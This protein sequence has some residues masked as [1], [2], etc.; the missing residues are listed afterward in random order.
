MKRTKDL[1]VARKRRVEDAMEIEER[2]QLEAGY[3]RRSCP[4]L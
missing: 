3:R 4:R 2:Q 1:E